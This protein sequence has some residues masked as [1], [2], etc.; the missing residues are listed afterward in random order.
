MSFD[1][2]KYLLGNNLLIKDPSV[3]RYRLTGEKAEF[4]KGGAV[5]AKQAQTSA[6]TCIN[7]ANGGIV[8]QN[9]TTDQMRYALMM[10]RK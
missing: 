1:P 10:R 2:D 4:A 6:Q 9:P 7:K 8:H 3:M 5:K